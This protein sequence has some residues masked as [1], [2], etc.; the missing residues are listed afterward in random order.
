[1]T[2]EE[3]AIQLFAYL[4]ASRAI[5]RLLL[6]KNYKKLLSDPHLLVGF[7]D[8]QPLLPPF[9]PDLASIVQSPS[10]YGGQSSCPAIQ[11]RKQPSPHP[12]DPR[13]FCRPH[14]CGSFTLLACSCR[15]P[16]CLHEE[17]RLACTTCNGRTLANARRTV[18]SGLDLTHPPA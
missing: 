11:A 7:S 3:A 4:C 1:M 12:S 16:R 13:N 14:T 18:T 15:F 2:A 9:I 10:S 5:H 17:E 8:E 6:F